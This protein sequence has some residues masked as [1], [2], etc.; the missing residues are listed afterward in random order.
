MK[1]KTLEN[2]KDLERELQIKLLE[3]KPRTLEY[4]WN[5]D[6][7]NG[8]IVGYPKNFKSNEDIITKSKWHGFQILR[9]N[10]NKF[11]ESSITPFYFPVLIKG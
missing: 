8:P 1:N 11:N 9:L 10:C 7:A 3:H 5:V 2:E 6:F 4:Q